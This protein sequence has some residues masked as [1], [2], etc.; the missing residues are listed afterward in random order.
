M[1]KSKIQLSDVNLE[2]KIS[3]YYEK[4]FQKFKEIDILP[5]SE[6]KA[7]HLLAY[8]CQKY[9][10]YYGFRYSFKFDDTSPTKSHEMWQMRKL[11]NMLT[12]DPTVLKQYLDWIFETKIIERKKKITSLGYF[13]HQDIVN[14]FK[15]KFLFNKKELSRAD[16]LPSSVLN[17]CT[18]YGK[19]EVKTYGDLAFAK[20]LPDMA[21]LIQAIENSGFDLQLL[22]K[23]I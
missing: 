6:W 10:E 3:P 1:P 20:R 12:A 16:Q 5:I 21:D 23:V 18:T 22:D 14:E 7:H 8:L 15:F 2:D 17:L 19:Q 9:E 13:T 4:F 11:A